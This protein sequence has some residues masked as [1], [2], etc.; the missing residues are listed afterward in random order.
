MAASSDLDNG[1]SRRSY[2]A[3]FVLFHHMIIH[4]M[5]PCGLA[6]H[7]HCTV[8]VSSHTHHLRVVNLFSSFLALSHFTECFFI[9]NFFIYLFIT[10]FLS[11]LI[12]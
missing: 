4:P 10:F 9:I 1:D 11:L 7:M 12:V 3:G 2:I 5:V 8:S 6:G